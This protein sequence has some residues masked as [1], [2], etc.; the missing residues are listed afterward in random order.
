MEFNA[1]KCKVMVMGK[2]SMKQ[3]ENL[4]MGNK[5]INNAKEEKD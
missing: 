4:S 1:K 2:S 5:Q 3:M